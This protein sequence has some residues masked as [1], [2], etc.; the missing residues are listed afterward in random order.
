MKN[1]KDNFSDQAKAYKKYRPEYPPELYK[2]VLALNSKRDACW[3]CGTGNGQVAVVLAKHYKR[4]YATDISENQLKHAEKRPNIRYGV[5]RAEQTGF[6]DDTFDLI[7]VAQAIHWF[8]F[9]AFN[10]EIKRVSKDKGALCVWG[11]GLLQTEAGITKVIDRF[12][13]ETI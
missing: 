4:V 8:D 12:Y 13:R 6:E 7:T 3:D 5:C 11:Y 10:K 9:E 2:A 1:T